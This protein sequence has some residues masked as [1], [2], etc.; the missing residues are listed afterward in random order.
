MP[1]QLAASCLV[2]YLAWARLVHFNHQWAGAACLALLAALGFLAAWWLARRWR[3][4]ASSGAAQ[5]LKQLLETWLG[6]LE[7]GHGP[8]ICLFMMLWH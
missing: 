1:L 8:Q 5:V 6:K 4:Q 7:V 2:S 3:R